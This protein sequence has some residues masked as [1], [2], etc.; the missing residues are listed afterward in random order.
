VQPDTIRARV[1]HAKSLEPRLSDEAKEVFIEFYEHERTKDWGDNGTVPITAR[2]LPGG[3]RLAEAHARMNLRDE[4]TEVDA[5]V[6]VDVIRAM[7]GDIY[8]TDGS[9]NADYRNGEAI[10]N[11]KPETQ[12]ERIED[13]K[14][15]IRRL[16]GDEPAHIDEI[17]ERANV[18]TEDVMDTIDK[19]SKEGLIYERKADHYRVS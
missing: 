17:V 10:T 13:V 5:R 9:M 1:A 11:S 12:Q 14:T 15:T 2:E 8:E 6:A 7:M 3:A 19:L 18:P 16:E 4:V